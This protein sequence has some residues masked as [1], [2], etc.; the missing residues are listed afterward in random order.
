MPITNDR[1][2]CAIS[3][4][5]LTACPLTAIRTHTFDKPKQAA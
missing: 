5:R 1:M 3:N 4:E 2:L